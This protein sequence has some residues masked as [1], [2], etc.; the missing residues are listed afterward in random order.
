MSTLHTNN[1]PETLTRLV[2]MGL[3]INIIATSITLIITQRLTHKLRPKCKLPDTNTEFSLFVEDS[4]LNDEILSQTFG[5]TLDKVENAKIYKANPK[6][7]PRCFKGYK[8]KIGLYEVMPVSRQISRM[9]L[10]DKNTMEIAV[11]VQKEGVA[12]LYDN[13]L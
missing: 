9:I 4:G 11:Q 1:A 10:E 6:G 2:D 8:G 3:P 5:V 12:I 7:C 13:Q